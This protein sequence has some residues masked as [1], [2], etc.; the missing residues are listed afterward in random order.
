MSERVDSD[1][2]PFRLVL[3]TR[4][5][6]KIREI[7]AILAGAPVEVL[8]FDEVG[9]WDEPEETGATLQENALIKAEA[10]MAATGLP[11]VAD[12][13]G[14]EVDALGGAPGVHS[15][16]FSGPDATYESNCAKLLADLDRSAPAGEASLR[17]ARFRTVVATAG[18]ATADQGEV[19]VEGALDGNI[20]TEAS[21]AGG[22]GYDPVFIPLGESRTLAAMSLAEKNEISHRGRA[23]KALA[24]ELARRFGA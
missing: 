1:D 9:P 8:T 14:L 11:S 24:D 4:N 5:D 12:D 13:T 22:F 20:A 10:V 16:R 3:A 18:L 17:S 19:I 7:R 21:G 6:D 15:A 2:R 23:F